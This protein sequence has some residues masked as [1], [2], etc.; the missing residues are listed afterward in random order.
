M[1]MNLNKKSIAG[2]VAV[3]IAAAYGV[4]RWR[5]GADDASE[6]ASIADE[7]VHAAD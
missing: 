7:Q 4:V 3:A 2:I 6:E 1:D 5:S